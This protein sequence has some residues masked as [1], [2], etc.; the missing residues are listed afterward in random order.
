MEDASKRGLPTGIVLITDQENRLMGTITEGDIRRGLLKNKDFAMSAESLMQKDPI[1]FPDGI[2]IIEILKKI[3]HELAQRNRRSK[4]YL[5]KI[6]LVDD[7]AIPTRILDYHQLWEQRV[8]SHRHIVVVGLGYVGLTLAVALADAGFSV[9]GVEANKKKVAQLLNNDCYIHEIG[10]QEMLQKNIGSRFFP[11]SKVPKEGDVF[12]ISVGTPVHSFDG[13]TIP[14]PELKFLDTAI[15][16]IA[17]CLKYGD[18]VVLRSTLPVGT[19]RSRVIP[20]LEELTNL[21]CGLDFHLAFAPERTAEGKAIK[22]LREL[23]QIIGGYN[24]DSVE[25]TVALFR[26]LTHTIVRVESLEVAEMAKLLNNS[27]RDFIFSFS[28]YSTQVAAKFNIDISET[29]KAANEGYPRDPIPYPSPGVGGPCL[30]KDPY[31]FSS[32]SPTSNEGEDLFIKG[33]KVN[34]SMHH[35][36]SGA[37]VDQ[38]KSLGKKPQNCKVLVCGLAFKGDPETADIR[39]SSSIEI[40]ENLSLEV[41]HVY[42]Y[43]PVADLTK[44]G[45]L[46]ITPIMDIFKAFEQMDVIAFL[47]NHKSFQKINVYEMVHLMNPHPII[48]DAWNIFYADDII[49]S[50]EAV[51]M[52]LSFTR[53]SII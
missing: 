36:V 24:A 46:P 45:Q 11:S 49:K 13:I 28:N 32:V 47:N 18:L 52:G 27:Y 23:P 48:Y 12:I 14:K 44:L 29:I 33:R 37:I 30:T 1:C 53:S 31:I 26:D 15:E 10:L 25:A 38:L 2:S 39:N 9:T 34:E 8:A 16:Q 5:N 6:I 40:A 3:P 41:A 4:K 42:G 21:R 50:R 7:Q 43:D 19:C 17:P 22:E 35:F 20:R 51:Y